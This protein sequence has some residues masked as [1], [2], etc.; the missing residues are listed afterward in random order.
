MS[1]LLDL[2]GALK[3]KSEE[4]LA[5]LLTAIAGEGQALSD[6]FDLSR[7]LLTRREL[8]RRI[9]ELD[10]ASLEELKA[11]NHT[12]LLQER[13]LAGAANTFEAATELAKTLDP[14]P[15][16]AN[17]HVQA[18]SPHSAYETL[19]A[20]TEL[21]FACE[22]NW[23]SV[24]RSGLRAQDAKELAEVLKLP[25][26]EI[27]L[28]FALAQETGL[29]IAFEDR[30]VAT[31]LGLSWLEESNAKRWEIIAERVFDLPEIKLR[32]LPVLDLVSEEYPL[33]NPNE[34]KFFSYGPALG[35]L[36]HGLATKALELSISNNLEAAATYL[37]NE[38][39]TPVEKLIIQA[40]LSITSPGPITP[41]LHKSLDVFAQS[42]DLG[43][44]CRFRLSLM[45]I[46]HGLETGLSIQDIESTLRNLSQH[47]LPQPVVYLLA[48]AT[49]RFGEL[50]VEGS[51]LGTIVR[52]SDKIL[53]A[54]IQNETGLNALMLRPGADGELVS[55]L[56]SALIYFNLR[57]AGY[58]AVMIDETGSIIS[59]RLRIQTP[60]VPLS[61]LALNKAKQLL[62][63]ESKEPAQDDMLRQLQFALKNKLRVTL[64][65]QRPEGHEVEYNIEPLGIA[66]GRIRGRDL[67]KEAELTLPLAR[68]T[69]VW[70]S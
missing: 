1:D 56:A 14:V 58:P 19:M 40:D 46:T 18:G 23:L 66:G 10:R 27:Q 70:L 57:Q 2:A 49:K 54:Q 39:P 37:A 62:S 22:R 3:S 45:S 55:R 11:G 33:K 9:R 24:I 12:T 7:V 29:I 20:I 52:C 16:K 21:L 41:A 38:L 65:L 34:L 4:D 68:V 13:M 30:F 60:D 32:D 61:Q 5:S 59:P 51:L 17:K 50:T 67:D 25:T 64:K 35:L 44:A 43:L 6:L 28:R 69:S 53:L 42:E 36:D 15:L 31:D 26:S 48:E 63:E 8:E 47:D